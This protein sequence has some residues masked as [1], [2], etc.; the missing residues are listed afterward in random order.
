MN[1]R[2]THLFIAVLV[3]FSFL[4]AQ[5]SDSI[6]ISKI[7]CNALNSQTAYKNLLE[8]CTNAPGRL[9]GTEA[10][11]KAM[12]ILTD[13]LK[14]AG[15]DTIYMQ[16]YKTNVWRNLSHSKASVEK[17]GKTIDL[18]VVALGPSIS[19][20]DNGI[21]AEIIEVKSLEELGTLGKE[22]ISGKI[23][24]FNGPMDNTKFNTFAAYSQ[25]GQQR[26]YGAGK[27]SEFG[28]L[29]VIIR[30][31][32]TEID[33]FPHTGVFRYSEG[34]PEIPAIAI[35]TADAEKLHKMLIAEQNL[36]ARIFTKTEIVDSVETGNIIAELK[37]SK[38]PGNI[39]LVGGHYDSWFN[40]PGANDDGAG[41]MQAIDI[42]RTFKDLGIRPEN[43]IRVVLFMDEEMNQTGAKIYA[44]NYRKESRPHI[45][46]IE[47]DAGG[48]LPSGFS[49]QA[50]DSIFKHIVALSEY[51]KQYD[52]YNSSTGHA[53][54][55]IAPLEEFGIPLIGL[56]VN[57]Q[58]YFEYH[59]SANDTP[60]KIHRRELQLG[61]AA[62]A[63]LVYLIDKYGI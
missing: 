17:D 29:G 46:A 5:Q 41:C 10:S 19:T 59:H 61:T 50:S 21:E 44:E 53:G 24:F 6:T 63:G 20:P 7:Y 39:I 30:S 1:K 47:S 28:A 42:I 43:T 16:K 33:N 14:T 18:N 8:L 9:I 56:K 23:V 4:H 62:I 49:V 13:Q 57:S 54:V 48:A 26:F 60:D 12:K 27:A 35:S 37:G 34:F 52:I 31:L 38:N 45:A 22:N 51:F 32:A 11:G 36:S 40:T 55:D 25:A 3:L 58:Q 15:A 2:Q